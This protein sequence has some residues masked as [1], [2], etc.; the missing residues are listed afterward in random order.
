M[1]KAISRRGESETAG[2]SRTTADLKSPGCTTE[3]RTTPLATTKTEFRKR[4]QR[5][6]SPEKFSNEKVPFFSRA[7]EENPHE[8]G[9]RSVPAG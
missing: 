5:N 3:T 2:W 1:G 6:G 8:S 4:R 7:D 9:R